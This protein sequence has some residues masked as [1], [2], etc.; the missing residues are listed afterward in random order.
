[1]ITTDINKAK[2]ILLQNELIAL[3]TETVYGLAGNAYNE[4]AIKKIFE[5]KKPLLLKI[6]S[7]KI[8]KKIHS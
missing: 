3:P 1:M 2:E 7:Q 4:T 5:L 6:C 8:C